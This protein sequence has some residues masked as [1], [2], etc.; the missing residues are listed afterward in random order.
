MTTRDTRDT[1]RVFLTKLIYICL[2]NSGVNGVEDDSYEEDEEDEETHGDGAL[3]KG[4]PLAGIQN[5]QKHSEPL[6]S[7]GS[8]VHDALTRF[9][10][11]QKTDSEPSTHTGKSGPSR[12]WDDRSSKR[13]SKRSPSSD[14]KS[15]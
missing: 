12:R 2:A 4:P 6:R 13:P 15:R 5:T 9:R 1:V 10:E 7:F 11:P 8:H 3:S 14:T